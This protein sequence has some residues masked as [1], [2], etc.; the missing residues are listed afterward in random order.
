MKLRIASPAILCLTLAFLGQAQQSTNSNPATSSTSSA[1][2][3][4]NNAAPAAGRVVI[5]VGDAQVTQAQF[6]T[7]VSDLEA[8][9]GPAD[10]TREAIGNNYA[11]LLMLSQ[12]AVENH[13]DSSPEVIR[14]LAL[15]RTQI[16]SNAEF[17]RLKSQAKPTA[18][19]ISAYYTAHLDDYDTVQLRRIFIWSHADGGAD[20]H[21]LSPQA[22]A[23]LAAQL[24]QALASGADTQKVIHN[25]PH[26]PNDVMV[27]PELL[28]FQRGEL[29]TKMEQAAFPLKEG[30]WT[31]LN[32]AP[33]TY[34]FLQVVKRGRRD[35]KDVSSQIEKKLQAQKLKDELS[36]LKKKTGVWMDEAYFA[37]AAKTPGSSTQSKAAVPTKAEQKEEKDEDKRQ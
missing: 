23:A 18:E 28:T 27:D 37:P 8:Q 11:Q 30:G 29:P 12:Q 10:L 16:L 3:A 17:A 20:G 21:A 36:D 26:N 4:M 2:A 14:Q 13:L 34:V 31:E 6:E 9:Q 33:G 7:M 24:R 19:E 15:D 5:K 1:P 35:L 25:T 32:D 22:A